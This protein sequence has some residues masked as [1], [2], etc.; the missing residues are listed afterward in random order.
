MARATIMLSLASVGVSGARQPREVILFSHGSQ[1][2]LQVLLSYR[3]FAETHCLLS[4]GS[5]SETWNTLPR[6]QRFRPSC[7]IVRPKSVPVRR[8]LPTSQLSVTNLDNFPEARMWI[9]HDSPTMQ[10]LSRGL[11][12]TYPNSIWGLDSEHARLLSMLRP[13][14][15]AAALVV[16][17]GPLFSHIVRFSFPA[18]KEF[19]HQPPPG[20]SS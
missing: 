16:R 5:L 1:T 19:C 11:L 7:P 10:A 8:S 13:F 4:E 2:M 6:L 15:S 17:F 20:N 12:V 18:H 9:V 14:C 3:V